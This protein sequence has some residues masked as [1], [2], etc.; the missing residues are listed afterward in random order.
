MLRN[1]FTK[2]G[3]GAPVAAPTSAPPAPVPNAPSYHPYADAAVNEIYNLLFCD[4][5]S[6]FK[7]R[8]GTPPAPWQATLYADPAQ[9]D[10]VRSL[11]LDGATEGRIRALAF[12]WLR[13]HGQPVPARQ[14]LGVI[15]EVPL[16]RGLDVLA[17]FVEGGVR[18]INQTGRLTIFEG[19]PPQLTPV[20]AQLLAQAQAIVDQIG[21]SD[22]PRR[23]APGAGKVRLSFLVS[24]G[25]YFGEGDFA[26]MSHEPRSAPLIAT[27]GELLQRVV[28]VSTR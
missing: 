23:P 2:L 15:I 24:D 28:Q 11:A 21:P 3:L 14:L 25:L 16:D 10:A 13:F 1:L 19:V 22:Q 9:P 18:Y 17:V 20:V 4:S 12:N 8:P 6:S 5:P 26:V 7:P 27:A